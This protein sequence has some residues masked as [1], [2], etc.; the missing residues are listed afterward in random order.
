MTGGEAGSNV[1]PKFVCLGTPS[2][3][4]TGL[5]GSI[6]FSLLP[7]LGCCWCAAARAR[8]TFSET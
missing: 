7:T 4:G 3:S 8:P 5:A 6:A 2:Q 1:H